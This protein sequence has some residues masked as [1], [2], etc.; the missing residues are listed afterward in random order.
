MIGQPPPIHS[1]VDANGVDV[2]T[3][4]FTVSTRDVSIGP[5]G[6]EGLSYVR[7][8]FGAGWTDNLIGSITNADP[9]YTVSFG[10]RSESFT[11]TGGVYVPAQGQQSTLTF[12]AA[13]KTYTYTTGAGAVVVFSVALGGPYAPPTFATGGRPT[14]VTWPDGHKLTY[15]YQTV[16]VCMTTCPGTMV[17][18][19]RVQ[20]ANNNAGYQLKLTYKSNSPETTA[21]LVDWTT[22]TSA[23][24]INNAIDYCDP[25]ANSCSGF[26][27]PWPSAAY[28]TTA[29]PPTTTT[30]TDALARVTRYTYSGARITGVKRPSSASDTTTIAYNGD[31]RVASVSNGVG[32]WRY[33]YS[34]VGTT[35]TTIVTD[36]LSNNRITTGDVTSDQLS[37]DTDA[38]GRKTIF[39]YDSLGRLNNV[40]RPEGDQIQYV[41]NP[42]G[43]IT[44]VTRVAKPGSPLANIV[45][46][47]AFDPTCT[48]P[49]KC[50]KPNVT[51]DANGGDTHYDYDPV[52][53]VPLTISGPIPTAGS[54]RPVTRL[55]YTLLYAWYK[56]SSGLVVRAA[57]PIYKL[58]GTSACQ[59]RAA[60]AGLADEVTGTLAYGTSGV[61]NNL[62]V[63]SASAGSGDGALTATTSLTYDAVGNRLTVQGPLGAAQ[64]SRYR[65]DPARQLTGVVGPDPDGAGPLKF[66]ALRYT[67]NLDGQA[68]LVERGTVASQSNFDWP[69][70]ATLEQRAQAYDTQGRPTQTSFASGGL[71]YALTQLGYDAA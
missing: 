58:T 35:A 48:Q 25:A 12:N 31:G 47:A 11:L 55:S 41:Y 62:A 59:T 24:G 65:Y 38:L 32:T 40:T 14:S 60:C 8:F 33:D 30:V 17:T 3:G 67:Y 10:G 44:K 20:S 27:T 18:A 13:A 4:A 34:V 43:N 23:T 64:T 68:T 46:T 5:A 42:R 28:A 69:A 70:F 22:V 57:T 53:G 19:S 45:T 66:P 9:T 36:P 63:T 49:A 52:Y 21:D 1:A 15:T 51:F 26:S 16:S 50:N 56:D 54:P 37:S 39:G 6:A 61:A 71:T 2:V 7:T 29:G